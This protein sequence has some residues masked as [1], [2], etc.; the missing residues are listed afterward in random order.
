MLLLTAIPEDVDVRALEDVE[1]STQLAAVIILDEVW[2]VV[3]HGV[4]RR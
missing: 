1:E 2:H 3:A 4:K